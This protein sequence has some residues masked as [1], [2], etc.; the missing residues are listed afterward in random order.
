M[1]EKPALI[2]SG[3]LVI[4]ASLMTI[5]STCKFIEPVAA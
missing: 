5:A 1:V 2:L 4:G 3:I